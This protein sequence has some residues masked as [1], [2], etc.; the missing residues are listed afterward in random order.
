MAPQR[1]DVLSVSAAALAT[2]GLAGC[3]SLQTTGTTT[4]TGSESET[5]T[6]TGKS[7]PVGVTAN[8]AVAAEW[9]AYRARV[10]DALAFG[11]AG[12]P[13]SGSQVVQNTFARFEGAT[14]E[15]GAHEVL[16]STG[17]S[18]YEGFE[19]ALGALRTEGLAADNLERAR[20]AAIDADDALSSAQRTVVD[21]ATAD[22]LDLQLLG[23]TAQNAEMAATVGDVESAGTVAEAVRSRFEASSASEALESADG[24]VYGRLE[25]ALDGVVAAAG[26][27]DVEGVRSE[28]AA[29]FVAAIEGSYVVAPTETH[30][31][32]GHLSAIQSRGWDAAALASE[33]GSS[34]NGA[35]AAGLTIY[36]ARVHDARWLAAV[37]EPGRASTI[38]QDVFAHFEGARAHEALESADEDAYEG[39]ESGLSSLQSAIE[40]GDASGADEALAAVDSNLLTGIEALGGSSAPL[41]ESAFFRARFADARERYRRGEGE[42]AGSIAEDLFARF[43]ENELGFHET[44]ESTSEE[45]YASFEEEHLSGLID[46]FSAGDDDAVV[47]HYEGVQSTLLEFETAAGSDATVSGAEAGYMAARGFDAS[48]LAALGDDARAQAIGQSAFQ[49]FESGAG[50]YHEALEEADES[51]YET[52]ESALSALIDAAGN[53]RDVSSAATRF[54][55]EAVASVYAIVGESGGSGS[56]GEAANRVLQGVFAHFEEARVHELVEEADRNAYQTFEAQLNAYITA[57][58]EDGNVNAAA[59]AFADASQYAQFALVD[60]VEDLPL[61]LDLAGGV[62]GSGDGSASGGVD[63]SAL[64]GGPN[65]VEGIPEDA[66]HIIEMQAVAFEPSELTVSQGDTVVWSHGAGEPHSVTAYEEEMPDSATYWASGGFESQSAAESGWEN[67][68]GA[69]QSGQSFVHTFETTGVHE[70]VCIPHEAAGMTGTVVVE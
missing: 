6:E 7:N 60:A 66:D 12:E 5:G 39:F 4:E 24:D 40:S 16:E 47:T 61:G 18:N 41:L 21:G 67:G 14:G 42:V 58:D 49:H 65:V 26:S 62:G 15:Y 25:S 33:G 3:S 22:A 13:G 51:Q 70:Y 10:W 11:V 50:G 19:E 45:L 43:E 64:Q 32:T 59:E 55:A 53:G 57:L 34:T 36:R 63:S 48:V 52:F 28:A 44:V 1:R 23:V 29:A 2:L 20:E 46:A 68:T 56:H 69:V 37:G 31:G 9:N 17:E 27:G 38:V 35:H 8:A 54:N 30:A